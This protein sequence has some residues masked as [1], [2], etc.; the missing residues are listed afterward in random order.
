M[1]YDLPHNISDE[2]ALN[3]ELDFDEF[4]RFGKKGY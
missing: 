3:R 2:I 1:L 4:A